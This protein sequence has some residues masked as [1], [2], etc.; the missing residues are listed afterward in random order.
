MS[1]QPITGSA[2]L[3]IA[4]VRQAWAKPPASM[5]QF[6]PWSCKCTNVGRI[7]IRKYAVSAAMFV[8]R[9]H[10]ACGVLQGGGCWLRHWCGG[11]NEAM[12]DI[13][14]RGHSQFN[15]VQFSWRVLRGYVSCARLIRRNCLHSLRSWSTNARTSTRMQLYFWD[16]TSWR[17]CRLATKWCLAIA[18]KWGYYH[19]L[20][21]IFAALSSILV[22]IRGSL[23]IAFWA[24]FFNSHHR[25]NFT[26]SLNLL[27]L[28]CAHC[29]F[30]STVR[31]VL[32]VWNAK[33]YR[34]STER[35]EIYR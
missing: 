27:K 29:R 17:I 10:V 6:G 31:R 3:Y 12:H 19:P 22:P 34:S 30:T 2:W 15:S 20:L 9:L 23:G 21:R 14:K 26:V 13:V 5:S 32:G 7:M 24:S 1:L 16:K 4:R 11:H 8:T 35:F 33:S 28:C 18:V 25:P